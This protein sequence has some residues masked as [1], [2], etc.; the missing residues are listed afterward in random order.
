M[1][2]VPVSNNGAFRFADANGLIVLYCELF[3]VLEAAFN[4][5]LGEPYFCGD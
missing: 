5:V 1:P 2:L 4:L 3:V